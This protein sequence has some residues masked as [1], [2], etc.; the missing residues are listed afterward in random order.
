LKAT[1]T[2]SCS[3]Q[4]PAPVPSLTVPTDAWSDA[5]NSINVSFLNV[6]VPKLFLFDAPQLCWDLGLM[7]LASTFTYLVCPHTITKR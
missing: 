7:S 1:H 6:S 2:R 5:R 4:S 3:S